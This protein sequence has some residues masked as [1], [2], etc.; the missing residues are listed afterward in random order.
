PTLDCDDTDA[1]DYPGAPETVGNE[2]DEDCDGS[3]ICYVDADDD[4]YR[5]ASTVASADDDCPDAGEA[6]ASDPAGDCD[7]GDAGDYPGAT[8]T[9]GNE[10]DED[11]DGYEICFV[12]ADNDGQ[13]PDSTSTVASLDTDCDDSGEADA[14][15]P[16]TDC[17]DSAAQVYLGA[18]E[19]V[20]NEVDNDCDGTEVC[21][22][23]VDSDGYRP[24]S[25]TTVAS[26]D[27]D[28]ADTGEASSSAPDGDCDDA[29]TAINP[30]ATELIGDGVD[31][32]CD[33]NETCYAD[34]DGDGDADESGGTVTSTDADCADSGE[35]DDTAPQTDCDDDDAS[36]S[37]AFGVEGTSFDGLDNDCD[38]SYDEGGL[39]DG[40]ELVI[41]E[42]M[43]APV[44]GE[45]EW[46]EVY[47]ATAVDLTLN[48]D[49]E[50]TDETSSG[51][52]NRFTLTAP[53]VI[54]AGEHVI[55]AED[56]LL[57]DATTAAT[58]VFSGL[59]FNN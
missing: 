7:D 42:I 23:D 14:T 38:D 18:T 41:T 58:V 28:C 44:G 40:D 1:G 32:D 2:D 45:G 8:E 21:Y 52:T 19:I 51:G 13:R 49:W 10:D 30:G 17:D 56:A 46:F 35:A 55:F 34:S 16:T 3:E 27:D 43:V 9:V 26:T 5:L 31:Q 47:N 20:G 50:I 53:V 48:E 4:G 12:D 11:C 36:V 54:G 37:G 24:D 59:G 57:N 25:V 33:G 15:E 6:P 39:L 22:V 29:T